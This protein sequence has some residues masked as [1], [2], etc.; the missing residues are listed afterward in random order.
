MQRRCCQT[1]RKDIMNKKS[2]K[3]L[4]VS[5]FRDMIAKGSL[6]LRIMSDLTERQGDKP[7]SVCWKETLFQ[8][9]ENEK[10]GILKAGCGIE[11]Q[12]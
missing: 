7:A 4:I 5:T 9:H 11:E 10:I 6:K 12:S 2:P 3:P 8:K 1:Q